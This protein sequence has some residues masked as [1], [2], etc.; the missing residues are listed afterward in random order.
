MYS[1]KNRQN[2]FIII[3]AIVI[4]AIFF[5]SRTP[6]QSQYIQEIPK[7]TG[8]VVFAITDLAADMGNITAINITIDSIIIHNTQNDSW[9]N[10]SVQQKV[11][12]LLQ[13]KS[14]NM[15]ALLH[16]YYLPEGRYNQIRLDIS[17]VVVDA[18]SG[19]K[20]AKLPSNQLKINIDLEVKELTTSSIL[21]D[22]VAD[23]SL[24]TTGTGNSGTYIFA[25]VVKLTVKEETTIEVVGERVN[26][27]GG[28]TKTDIEI[29]M[30]ERGNVGPDRKIEPNTKMSIQSGMIIPY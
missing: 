14:Q 16:E 17:R 30:D 15:N 2:G 13:L 8:R 19:N 9:I 20:V 29:G 24:H 11:V 22:F 23:K 18:W 21:F 26:I 7:N 4:I 1:H 3:T 10:I 27:Y 28:K 5:F 12:D 6:P 25:P